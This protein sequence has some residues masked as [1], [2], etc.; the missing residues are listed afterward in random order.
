MKRSIAML[1][2]WGY[3]DNT[4]ETVSVTG[5]QFDAATRTVELDSGGCYAGDA[6]VLP[7][8]ATNRTVTYTSSDPEILF[9]QQQRLLEPAQG[10]NSN[11][12]RDQ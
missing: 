12:D 9:C 2:G 10:R 11:L 5:V 4:D 6:T 1:S 7:T 3:L 8:N